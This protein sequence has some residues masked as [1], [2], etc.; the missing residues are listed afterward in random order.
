LYLA[1]NFILI[2][3]TIILLVLIVMVLVRRIVALLVYVLLR[4]E[5]G[6]NSYIC[7]RL[8]LELSRAQSMFIGEGIERKTVKSPMSCVVKRSLTVWLVVVMI[9][10]FLP[11][12][13]KLHVC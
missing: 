13:Y 8:K 11:Y 4:N 10:V 12:S 3:G 6:L 7:R 2:C 5:T 9:N 1:I